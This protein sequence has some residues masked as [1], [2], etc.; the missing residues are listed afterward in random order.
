MHIPDGFLSAPVWATLDAL[1]VPAVAWAARRAAPQSDER[2]VPLMGVMG[3][4]VFAAQM[5]NFPVGMGASAHLL[6]GALLACILGPAAAVLVMSAV[7]VLQ[8]L[9]FQDGGILALGAN[10]CNMALAGVAA[11]Y[12]PVY[13]AGRRRGAIFLGGVLSVA[14]SASLALGQLLLSGVT[15]P[16]RLVWV[17]LAV[18]AAGGLIEGVI[19]VA[20]VSAIE[21][22]QPGALA[23]AAAP[24]SR[25]L[26]A[27]GAAAV[28]LLTA[29]VWAVSSD[30][31]G[32][33]MLLNAGARLR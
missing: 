15:M 1:A 33:Q 11:G 29:G 23:P 18:F 9:V 28:A 32:L 3:A 17:S 2:L 19:T 4:F 26:V 10:V 16:A 25:A 30:P 22:I 14:V 12:L 20:A 31:D 27:I 5:V 21:R 6:G 7:L 8:A 13:L 24:R